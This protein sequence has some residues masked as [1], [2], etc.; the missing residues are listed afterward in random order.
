MVRIIIDRFEGD[1]AIVE[2]EDKRTF[3]L[4]KQLLSSEAREGDVIKI[5]ID[6]IETKKRKAE[7]SDLMSKVLKK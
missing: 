2:L 3:V 5:E 7:L 4:P 6:D 1:C